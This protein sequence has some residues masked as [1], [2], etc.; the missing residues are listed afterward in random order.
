MTKVQATKIIDAILDALK[1][2]SCT[3]GDNHN[4][5][6]DELKWYREDMILTV[7]ANSPKAYKK[8]DEVT[9]AIRESR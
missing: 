8:K 2:G 7:R 4:Y 5:A 3:W 6:Y 1:P 9:N